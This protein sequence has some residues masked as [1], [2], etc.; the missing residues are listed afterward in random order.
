MTGL[1]ESK[2][3]I[4]IVLWTNMS[5]LVFYKFN[6]F[7]VKNKMYPPKTSCNPHTSDD[8]TKGM[9]AAELNDIYLHFSFPFMFYK[10][11]LHKSTFE[12]CS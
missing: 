2:G 1:R 5:C 9:K 10:F 6:H 8:I 4:Y 3:N 7:V 11:L 12:F